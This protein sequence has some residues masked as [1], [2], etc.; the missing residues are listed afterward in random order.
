MPGFNIREAN[1]QLEKGRISN[2]HK[3]LKRRPKH[4]WTPYVRQWRFSDVYIVNF[5][6]ISHLVLVFLL[7]T[8]NM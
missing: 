1:Y 3:T 5:K 2:M 4:F 6:H 8:L 7:F